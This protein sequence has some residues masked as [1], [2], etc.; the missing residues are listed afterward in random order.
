MEE[1][2]RSGVAAHGL[3]LRALSPPLGLMQ[4][5]NKAARCRNLLSFMYVLRG[6]ERWYRGSLC[7]ASWCL[8]GAA[9]CWS[10]LHEKKQGGGK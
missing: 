4:A 7:F 5:C 8:R 1:V 2:A 6:A 3:R 9:Y 10:L